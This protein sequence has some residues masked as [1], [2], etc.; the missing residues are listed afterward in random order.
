[1][2]PAIAVKAVMQRKFSLIVFGWAQ[3][4]T[5]LEP[6]LSIISGK[7]HYHG[8]F[9]TF[10]GATLT[11]ALAAGTGKF[12]AER[13]LRRL[14]LRRYLPLS[15][16]VT[17]TSA[18]IGTFSHIVLDS[19]V[20]PNAKPFAPFSSENIFAGVFN[21]AALMVFCVICALLGG[22]VFFQLQPLDKE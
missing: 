20:H 10:L 18:F 8:F 16:P 14:R 4:L 13:G 21:T 5:D 2:G 15:W 17:I 9:H 11:G 7:G 3:I 19:M 22:V 12:L 6:L 1:M